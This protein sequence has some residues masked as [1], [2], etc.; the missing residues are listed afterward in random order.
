MRVVVDCIDHGDVGISYPMVDTMA[1]LNHNKQSNSEW[2][3]ETVQNRSWVVKFFLVAYILVSLVAK[4]G[5]ADI[6]SSPNSSLVQS[7]AVDDQSADEALNLLFVGNSYTAGNDLASLTKELVEAE[8]A[9]RVFTQSHHPGGV[10]FYDHV[11]HATEEANSWSIRSM[12]LET[13][14]D[15]HT[16]LVK[17]PEKWNWVILQEQS[18]IPGFYQIPGFPKE[19]SFKTSEESA[20]KLNS[21]IRK[22][23]H[24]ETLFLLT[25]GRKE[26]DERNPDLYPDF[27]TMQHRLTHGYKRYVRATSTKSRP[28]YVAPV[29]LVFERIYEDIKKAGLDPAEEGSLFDQ[30]Y[31]EDGSHPSLAGSYV[32]ALTIYATIMGD[33]ARNVYWRP[34][35][36]EREVALAIQDAVS[37]TIAYTASHDIITYPWHHESPDVD[38]KKDD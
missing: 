23:P 26:Y 2:V 31:M 4:F 18:Q 29:G 25:W 12:G 30:L 20:A 33:D 38:D 36:L 27:K 35:G 9:S 24:A 6:E 14:S 3:C 28:T 15:L 22:I 7:N 11:K 5:W 8:W 37:R 32:A 19:V 16:W 34:D 10:T 21:L 13:E 17:R 1:S